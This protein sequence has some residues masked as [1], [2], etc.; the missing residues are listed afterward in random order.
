MKLA[1][2][3]VFILELCGRVNVFNSRASFMFY[4]QPIYTKEQSHVQ[5]SNST[6]KLRYSPRLK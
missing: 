4:G 5:D 3:Y 6:V 2:S 1:K